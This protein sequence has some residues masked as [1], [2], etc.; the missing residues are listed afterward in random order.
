MTD[1]ETVEMDFGKITLFGDSIPKGYTTK[2]GKIEKV[3]EDAVTRLESHYGVKVENRSAYGLTL[4]KLYERGTV[5]K[6]IAEGSGELRTAVFCIG[7]N[8]SDYD[9]RA[10]A[11]DPDGEHHSKTPL[12]KFKRELDELIVKLQS[13]DITVLL[14]NLPP[15]DSKRYF[16]KVISK[17]ADG[18]QVLRFFKGDL[19]NINRH[20]EGYNLA[21][22][23][24]AVKNGCRL[25]DI[26][27]PFLLQIDYLS[28]Y[29]DDGIHPNEAGH[30]IIAESVMRFID[31]SA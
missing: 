18:E 8:D 9:W 3:R 15:V 26:R 23:E 5:D 29:S 11:A 13:A 31:T 25:I 20:Q 28:N 24:A 6:F 10:V 27:S 4:D 14:T 1:G 12:D 22:M 21:I 19:T 2:R 30:R 7:G 16:D 17:I